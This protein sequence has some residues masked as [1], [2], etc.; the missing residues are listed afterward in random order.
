MIKLIEKEKL[1]IIAG[2]GKTSGYRAFAIGA[3][4]NGIAGL[5]VNLIN[6]GLNLKRAAD[7]KKIEPL[8]FNTFIP[9][10]NLTTIKRIIM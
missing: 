4:I 2:A 10:N 3:A 7:S 9:T 5:V 6:G 1:G 8:E